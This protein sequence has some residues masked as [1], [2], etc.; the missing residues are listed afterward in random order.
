MRQALRVVALLDLAGPL[1]LGMLGCALVL[2]LAVLA[3]ALLDRPAA[4]RALR[5]LA[6]AEAA[7][8]SPAL[9]LALALVTA[10]RRRLVAIDHPN[11]P[12][13]FTAGPGVWLRAFEE[14]E[15]T[16]LVAGASLGVIAVVLAAAAIVWAVRGGSGGLGPGA[17]F[18]AALLPGVT[19]LG[20]VRRAQAMA[21][22]PP[23]CSRNLGACLQEMYA[24]AAAPLDEARLSVVVLAAAGAVMLAGAAVWIASRA[25]EPGRPRSRLGAALVLLLGL[26]AYRATRPL[27]ADGARPFPSPEPG[28]AECPA[29]PDLA[30][31]LPP[32]GLCDG[33]LDGPVIQVRGGRALL[34][35]VALTP[36]DVGKSL[37]GK[38]G[39]LAAMRG[40]RP[41]PRLW[42]TLVAPGSTPLAELT[43][44]LLAVR[45]GLRGDVAIATVRPD[46]AVSTRTLGELTTGPLCCMTPVHLA[47]D[48]V[49]LSA[50]ETWGDL[51]RA[52]AGARDTLA[53]AV[54]PPR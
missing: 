28:E 17:V 36:D 1:T 21:H 48:G 52:A 49:P 3:A 27:A 16:L 53:V 41:M 44:Y 30:R 7:C 50:F 33:W 4:G 13:P 32:E 23:E 54:S 47:D 46:R 8:L 37:A 43:P 15:A 5:A 34:D 9:L 31:A 18:F 38:R 22:T 14:A 24:S 25:E 42:A 51:A 10:A 2:A 45:D 39:L 40:A 19:A 6:W 29:P 12:Y 35:G 11:G 26:A 20:V